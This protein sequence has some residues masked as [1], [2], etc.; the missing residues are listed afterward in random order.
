MPQECNLYKKEKNKQVQCLACAHKCI[1]SENKTG[2]C[3]VRKNI[4][5]K[6][7]LLVYG[8]IASIG[9]D[10]IEKKPLYHF[11][12]KTKT[13]S[14]GTIG[15]NFKCENCQ[16]FDI[17]QETNIFG[18]NYTPEQIINE[19]IKTNCKSI[20]YTYNE[21]IIFAEFI[22]ETAKI[23]KKNGLKNI[24]VTNGFWTKESFDYL[25]DLIDAVNIDIKGNKDF[26]KKICKTR[27]QP[28]LE[29]IKR[30]YEQGI[31][32]EI[33]TLLIPNEND[34]KKTL[35]TIA[36]FILSLDK[37][38]PWHLSRFF[39]RYKMQDKKI[40]SKQSLEKAYKIGIEYLN[41]VYLGNI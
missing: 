22:Y 16:N 6:L 31:H 10:S 26:Y 19:A 4:N 3:G 30:C 36:K 35:T 25:K 8:K 27:L 33:T 37:N 28:V 13:F 40:T 32:I 11:L 34:D 12:P 1:I 41:N 2:I 20:S 17:S 7:I 38:I 9:I 14:F 21:P 29:T 18:E 23:A 24:M 39:P 15:C 5:G